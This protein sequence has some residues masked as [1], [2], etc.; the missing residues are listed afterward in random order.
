MGRARKNRRAGEDK[1]LCKIKEIL[2]RLDPGEAEVKP[3]E[4]SR[5]GLS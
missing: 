3:G 2:S 4:F 5:L 1:I